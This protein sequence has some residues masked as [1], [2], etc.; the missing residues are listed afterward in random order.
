MVVKTVKKFGDSLHI[1]LGKKEGFKEADEVLVFPTKMS[2]KA[3]KEELTWK[4]KQ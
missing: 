2:K 1:V 3:I 4:K